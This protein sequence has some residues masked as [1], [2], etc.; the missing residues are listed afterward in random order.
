MDSM[1]VTGDAV[2][3]EYTSAQID[4]ARNHRVV[5]ARQETA[6]LRSDGNLAFPVSILSSLI[7]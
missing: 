5:Y 2:P 3:A 7:T 4:E 6:S 1:L